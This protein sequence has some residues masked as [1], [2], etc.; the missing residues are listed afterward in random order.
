MSRELNVGFLSL[1]RKKM[2]SSLNSDGI[3]CHK[4]EI[5]TKQSIVINI[6][7]I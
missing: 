5:L 4:K 2:G 7:F 1:E 6:I 3:R